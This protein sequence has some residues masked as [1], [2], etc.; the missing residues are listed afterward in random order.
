MDEARDGEL[1]RRR[2]ADAGPT[3]NYGEQR[4][5]TLRERASEEGKG[6]RGPVMPEPGPSRRYGPGV[7][8][9]VP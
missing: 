3:G 8:T 9:T 4:K 1:D 2:T 7:R 6:T 5:T